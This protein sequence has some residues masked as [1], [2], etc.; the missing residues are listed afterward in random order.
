MHT[1]T[2]RADSRPGSGF[3]DFES[4]EATDHLY[5]GHWQ[6]H[7]RYL[8]EG[9]ADDLDVSSIVNFRNTS[10]TEQYEFY[11]TEPAEPLTAPGSPD[12]DLAAPTRR[13]GAHRVPTPPAALKGRAAVLA[14]AAGAVV[15]AGQA[16]AS[17]PA[18]E[19]GHSEVALAADAT[20]SHVITATAVPQAAQFAPETES[21]GAAPSQAPQVLNIADPNDLS[22]FSNLLAKGQRFSEERAAREAA[23]RRP[24]FV[25][26]AAGVFTSSYGARWGTLHAGV[27]I[28]GPIGTPI[29]AVADGTVIDSGP[30]SGFGMWVRLRHADG[31][32]T[33]YGHIDQSMVTVGQQVMAGDQIATMGNRGQSTG[34]HLH[35]EVHLNGID[36]IDPLPWLATRGISLGIRN[37]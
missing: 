13:G 18:Q 29:L 3:G 2:P 22:Q 12:S 10:T 11:G 14:V 9:P 17:G 31:T 27:D 4:T 26:P 32:V 33:V 5:P 1:C 34:P 16:A 21:E 7:E 36:K 8:D 23:A 30:A 19:S 6:P 28:A 25:L 24:L 37:D 35:F 20:D 15:A